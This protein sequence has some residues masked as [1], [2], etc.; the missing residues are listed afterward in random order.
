MTFR[1][2]CAFLLCGALIASPAWAL[3]PSETVEAF[4]KA[5]RTGKA[6]AAVDYLG[7]EVVV[8]EQGFI[9]PSRAEFVSSQLQEAADFATRTERRVIRREAW[10]DGNI[11]WVLSST[12]TVGIFEGRKLELEGAETM[13]MRKDGEGWK[14]THIH[15]SAHP[16]EQP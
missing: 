9:N 10:Q 15:W 8:F 7:P 11:A 12:L 2:A 4:H 1:L 3:S 13:V 14:I 16:I 6:E 5:L